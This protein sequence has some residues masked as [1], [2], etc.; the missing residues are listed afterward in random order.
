MR[1][2]LVVRNRHG[3]AHSG[4]HALSPPLHIWT[5]AREPAY[6][7]QGPVERLLV[8]RVTTLWDG[9]RL[10]ELRVERVRE[11]AIDPGSV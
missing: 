7:G 2:F 5:A 9:E 10:L 4:L 3:A 1:R 8:D 6:A 11:L